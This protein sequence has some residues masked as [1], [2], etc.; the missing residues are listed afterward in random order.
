MIKCP[1]CTRWNHSEG[2]ECFA[3]GNSLELSPLKIDDGTPFFLDIDLRWIKVWGTLDQEPRRPMLQEGQIH[4]LAQALRFAY[5]RGYED[6]LR[7]DN[8]G[9]RCKLYLDNGFA[10]P[11]GTL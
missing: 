8:T 11:E 6:A 4:I 9:D 7:E 3:C 2:R 10:P 5:S 1:T